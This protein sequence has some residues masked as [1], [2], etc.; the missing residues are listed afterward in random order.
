MRVAGF[1][2]H[3]ALTGPTLRLR[4]LVATDHAGLNAGASGQAIWELHRANTWNRCDVFDVYFNPSPCTGAA[5]RMIDGARDATAGTSR[6]AITD[7]VSPGGSI[8]FT[9]PERRP[10]SGQTN[11][12]MKALILD[13]LSNMTD[14][15]WPH[16]NTGNLR[17]R[18]AKAKPGAKCVGI[19][20]LD[21]DRGA[22][23]DVT[24]LLDRTRWRTRTH[25]V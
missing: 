18:Q 9:F 11:R 25:H 8:G 7:A 5:L 24:Y 19:R 21:L 23:D 12:K 15:A 13:H 6:D 14:I 3:P 2:P 1:D 17:S 22:D 20:Q 4:P 10:R 16:P